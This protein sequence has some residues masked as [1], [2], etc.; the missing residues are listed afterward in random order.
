[1]FEAGLDQGAGLRRQTPKPLLRLVPVVRHGSGEAESRMLWQ[2]AHALTDLDLPVAVLDIDSHE[3]EDAPGLI[4]LL[5]ERCSLAE[6]LDETL[7]WPIVP[8][9][10]GWQELFRQGPLSDSSRQALRHWFGAYSVLL[11]YGTAERLGQALANTGVRPLVPVAPEPRPMLSAYQA[12][13]TLIAQA[14]LMPSVAIMVTQATETQVRKALQ[15]RKTLQNCFTRHIGCYLDSMTV[16]SFTD[17]EVA[18]RD[19]QMLA[20]RLMENAC[21]LG[22]SS[23]SLLHR[24]T[25]EE[26][27]L[28]RSH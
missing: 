2:L 21:S 3:T 23:V 4:E 14:L 19:I 26:V 17:D 8:A 9:A 28:V 24:P 7:P 10:V 22:A 12:M 18:G 25:D 1:M 16:K 11:V 5:Q 13:K 15:A 20:L 6:V 27:Q